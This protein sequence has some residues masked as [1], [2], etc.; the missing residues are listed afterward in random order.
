M[1]LALDILKKV[2]KTR[3]YMLRKNLQENRRS[4]TEKA[5][6]FE[7]KDNEQLYFIICSHL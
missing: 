7:K 2:W 1:I 6:A 4:V 3:G 5:K